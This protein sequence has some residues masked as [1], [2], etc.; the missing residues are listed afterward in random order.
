MSRPANPRVAARQARSLLANRLPGSRRG[1]VRQH[2]ARSERISQTIWRRWHVGPHQWQ[3]KHLRWFLVE[4]TND[5]VSCTRYRYWL[6]V[7][8]LIFALDHDGWVERL[9][10]PWVRPSGERGE[11]KAGRPAF[12]P[13]PPV[14]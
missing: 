13:S 4:K 6:T 9:D 10:G 14:K 7:R 11:L 12:L 2:L 3:L 1:T 5:C 8:L